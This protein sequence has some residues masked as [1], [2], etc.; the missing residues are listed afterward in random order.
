MTIIK[1]YLDGTKY[2]ELGSSDPIF[3]KKELPLPKSNQ[4]Y[5]FQLF[6]QSDKG[7]YRILEKSKYFIHKDEEQR[8]LYQ[9]RKKKLFYMDDL[10]FSQE[11]T[12]KIFMNTNYDQFIYRILINQDYYQNILSESHL[13]KSELIKKLFR[14]YIYDIMDVELEEYGNII[15]MEINV[16][17]TKKN[18]YYRWLKFLY[19]NFFPFFIMGKY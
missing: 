3:I 5:S 17:M 8:Y 7:P 6:Y 14:H 11:S 18:L 13:S 16:K 10:T 1:I 2:F 12:I 4:I 19:R 15:H 9:Y